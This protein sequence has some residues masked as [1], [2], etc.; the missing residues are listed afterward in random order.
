MKYDGKAALGKTY[1]SMGY[2]AH[3]S[4]VSTELTSSAVKAL[5]INAGSKYT[6]EEKIAIVEWVRLNKLL[7]NGKLPAKPRTTTT[8]AK[9]FNGFKRI[10]FNI[11]SS[12]KRQH[13][14]LEP[15]YIAA[16][17]KIAPDNCNQWLGETV[18]AHIK[19][20]GAESTTRIIKLAIVSK[21][22]ERW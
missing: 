3:S 22:M 1:S 10:A 19:A 2:N 16:L 13:I 7:P 18:D 15:E 5:K 14:S 4:D 21:L 17:D 12:P 6:I 20:Y 8:R 11:E 9:P